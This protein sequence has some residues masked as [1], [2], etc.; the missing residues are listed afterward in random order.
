MLHFKFLLCLLLL[1]SCKQKEANK[2]DKIVDVEYFKPNFNHVNFKQSQIDSI[3]NCFDKDFSGSLLIYK[4]NKIFRKAFGYNDVSK[5]QKKEINDV[6][7]LA[8]VSKTVTA[9]AILKLHQSKLLHIDSFYSKYINGFPYKNVT[10][11]QLLTHRSGLANYIYYMDTFW[12]DKSVMM[13]NSDL[14]EFFIKIKPEPYTKPNVSF[15]YNNTNF[16]L[17]PPL[18][19]KVSKRSFYE[20][21]LDSIFKPCGIRSSFFYACPK[22]KDFSSKVMIGR[23]EKEIYDTNYYLN[24]IHGD[25]SLYSS[26]DD[27]FL[28][29]EGM[30][31]NRIVDEELLNAMHE[32]SYGYNVYGG[33]YGMGFRLKK[34]KNTKMVYHN[35]WWKGFWTYFWFNI[36]NDSC[37]IIL[38]NNKKST[39]FK[40]YDLINFLN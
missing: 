20:F 40:L 13:K 31:N 8:S 35:G 23:Y 26:V 30:K 17:L 38:T 37:L 27:L 6:Y 18:I 9:L 32:P 15:S 12:K 11:R 24:T 28:L 7:Q 33:S 4:Q 10:I 21:V 1:Y 25:K 19:E 2:T 3:L 36:E 34:L 22:S 16:A 39:H 29:Y 5:T 14:L